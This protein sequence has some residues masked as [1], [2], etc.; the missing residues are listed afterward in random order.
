ML[1]EETEG[2]EDIINWETNC[3]YLDQYLEAA[4]GI[5]FRK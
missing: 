4:G 3:Q 1:V 5:G 2:G